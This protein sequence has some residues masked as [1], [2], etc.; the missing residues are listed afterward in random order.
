MCQI[1]RMEI[2]YK[3]NKQ[4]YREYFQLGLPRRLVE[5]DSSVS[6]KSG[7]NTSSVSLVNLDFDFDIIFS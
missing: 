7:F 6:F 1:G 5:N 2:G 3:V 4:S